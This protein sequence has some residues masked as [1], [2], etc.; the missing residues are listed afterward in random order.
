[1]FEVDHICGAMIL[2]PDPVRMTPTRVSTI[3]EFVDGP[4][5]RNCNA[6]I[7]TTATGELV[8]IDLYHGDELQ[9]QAFKQA[10]TQEVLSC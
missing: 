7:G 8:S 3:R 1:M 4:Q 10:L 2:S 9:R 5:G 6:F